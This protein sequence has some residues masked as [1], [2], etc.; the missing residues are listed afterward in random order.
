MPADRF[1]SPPLPAGD[2][3]LAC[4][5]APLDAGEASRWVVVPP[6]GAVV[7]FCGTARDHAGDRTGVHR[8]EYEAY[9]E[10][11]V[12]VLRAVADGVRGRWPEL[13]RLVLWH[14]TGSLAVGDV[15]VVVAVSTPH[16]DGAFDAARWALDEIKATAPIW[17]REHHD[18]GVAWGRCDHRPGHGTTG[19]VLGGA[20]P[21]A[22]PVR[23]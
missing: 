19:A 5:D 13:G 16:R 14:R 18:G 21:V 6:C 3:W 22:E 4:S 20:V 1:P 17:K 10:H 7:T 23:S 12:P 15:A 11:V 8:L 9:D 2:D